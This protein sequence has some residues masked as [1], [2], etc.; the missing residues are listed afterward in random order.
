MSCISSAYLFSVS[1]RLTKMAS[2][3][4]GSSRH[5]LIVPS[6]NL[7]RPRAASPKSCAYS[8]NS[9][10][11]MRIRTGSDDM[12]LSRS[13][14]LMMHSRERMSWFTSSY[15][16]LIIRSCIWRRHFSESI[17]MRMLSTRSSIGLVFEAA[18]CI[19]V[20]NPWSRGCLGFELHLTKAISWVRLESSVEKTWSCVVLLSGWTTTCLPQA[21]FWQQKK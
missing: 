8:K 19:E 6:A 13:I 4:V 9:R 16:T 17:V 15:Q 10:A 11:V 3:Y 1:Q 5:H 2:Q 14:R 18:T 21:R 7:P 20:P 12:V